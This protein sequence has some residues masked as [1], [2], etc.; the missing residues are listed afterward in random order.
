MNPSASSQIGSPEKKTLFDDLHPFQLF[1]ISAE[2][3]EINDFDS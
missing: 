2:V 3:R 1:K